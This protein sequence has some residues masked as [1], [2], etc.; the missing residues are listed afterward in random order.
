MD[1]IVIVLAAGRG[2]R[3]RASGGH[4]DKLN[5]LLA[6]RR[7]R[8]HVLDAVRASDL[9]WHIVERADTAHLP[10]PGMGDSIA[11]GVRATPHAAG[12]LILPADLPL[13]EAAT[14][15]AVAACLRQGPDMGVVVPH[16]QGE[17]G[18]PVGF[19]AGCSLELMALTGDEGARKVMQ[20]HSPFALT[21]EDP[22][23]V[24][25]VDTV[26][27]LAQAEALFHSRLRYRGESQ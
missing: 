12:W 10:S 20:A 1:P 18:H 23:C 2:E 13:V 27:R 25:D 11:C 8:D 9:P 5:S 22:G 17:R 3:F 7:V 21:V 14:L 16:Y 26:E 19:A 4:T 24:L 6:G 15:R